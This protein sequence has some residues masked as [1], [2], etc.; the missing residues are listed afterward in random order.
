MTSQ[1]ALDNLNTMGN[2]NIEQNEI[3]L[4]IPMNASGEG[5]LFRWDQYLS[6]QVGNQ[7]ENTARGIDRQENFYFW[8]GK[9]FWC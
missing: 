9:Y 3:F 6:W 8:I 7:G 5:K 1:T 2:P 4:I